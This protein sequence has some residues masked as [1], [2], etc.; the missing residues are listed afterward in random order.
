MR[1]SESISRRG[2][3]QP[4]G[5]TALTVSVA[6]CAGEEELEEEPEEE[7]EAE[8]NFEDQPED[9][10][11]SFELPEDGATVESPV[12]F[13]VSVEGADL[14]PA[15]ENV[16]GAGHVHIY[17]DHEFFERGEVIPGPAPQIEEEDGIYHWSDAQTEDS[18]ELK[19]GEYTVG[20][21]LGD[22][23]H[24]AFGETDEITVTVAE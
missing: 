1:D 18:I 15:G 24:R 21:Q 7:P 22:G 5:G 12:E 23:A 16:V 6:G 13:E 2:I 8:Y 14:V 20:A 19:P 17:F 4:I 10:A 11:V 9:A 3:V